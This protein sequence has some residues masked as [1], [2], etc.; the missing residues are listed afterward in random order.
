MNYLVI[1]GYKDAAEKFSHESGIAPVVQLSSIKDRMMIRQAVHN[2]RI[3]EAIQL[4][5]D[6]DPEVK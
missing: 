3:H 5:N 1:E 4:V 2:G 6:L